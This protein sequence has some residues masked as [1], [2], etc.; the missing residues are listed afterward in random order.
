M[1]VVA[2]HTPSAEDPRFPP[3]F[4]SV[5]GEKYAVC[6]AKL[7]EFQKTLLLRRDEILPRIEGNYDILHGKEVA[8]ESTVSTLDLSF[9]QYGSPESKTLGCDAI[10]P[11]DAAIEDVY[12]FLD[13]VAAV[14]DNDDV[15]MRTYLPYYYQSAHQL[16]AP[17]SNNIPLHGFL[18]HR[19][20]LETPYFY[21]TTDPPRP[22]WDDG[23]AMN[24]IQDWVKSDAA[25][26]VMFLY[27]EFD[28]YTA[29]AFEINPAG[30]N[31]LYIAPGANHG[32]WIDALLPVEKEEATTIL[33][34]WFGIP[35]NQ[36]IAE[37]PLPFESPPFREPRIGLL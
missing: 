1:A 4:A 10:P 35:P 32:A 13:R 21:L 5:G 15:N 19:D 14:S 37:Q 17:A 29:A 8:F 33:K 11:P 7:E 23:K 22:T 34:R 31:H 28:P 18:R 20:I 3:F 9:W 26:N 25:K 6:R 12:N 24:D 27:G 2:P 36:A 30:D 16:G